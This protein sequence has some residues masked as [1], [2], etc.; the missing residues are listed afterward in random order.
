MKN[1]QI[2]LSKLFDKKQN[3]DGLMPDLSTQYCSL[4]KTN[5][6]TEKRH[7]HTN[8]HTHART[9]THTLCHMLHSAYINKLIIKKFNVFHHVEQFEFGPIA[10]FKN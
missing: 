5:K 7:T 3:V 2:V 6:G 10:T 1:C 4:Q 9:H 8:T